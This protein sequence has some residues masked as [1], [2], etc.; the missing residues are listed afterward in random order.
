ML[1]RLRGLVKMRMCIWMRLG[2]RRRRGK[3]GG[4][5][6]SGGWNEAFEPSQ[7]QHGPVW[8]VCVVPRRRI[9]N[10]LWRTG[11]N[12]MVPA[13]VGDI[14]FPDRYCN[15]L[16]FFWGGALCCLRQ[17]ALYLPLSSLELCGVCCMSKFGSVC[18]LCV[19]GYYFSLLVFSSP[20]LR[21]FLLI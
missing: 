7:Q 15:F 16:S 3:R 10:T 2:E 6:G 20:F 19:Y 4:G 21:I 11:V 5:Y 8:G 17:S 9:G 18:G 13:I 1:K 12:E 14:F